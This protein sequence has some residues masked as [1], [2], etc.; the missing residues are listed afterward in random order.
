MDKIQSPSI[1]TPTV[2]ATTFSS[3]ANSDIESPL[4]NSFFLF[5]ESGFP[6]LS[7]IPSASLSS[8]PAQVST[9]SVTPTY[10]I[11]PSLDH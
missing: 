9:Q 6:T 5:L 3:E 11:Q 1:F 10:Y 4:Y 8:P 2:S 7:L